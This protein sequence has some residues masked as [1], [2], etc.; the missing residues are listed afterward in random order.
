MKAPS[1]CVASAATAGQPT[2]AARPRPR[3]RMRDAQER[4]PAADAAI[5]PYFRD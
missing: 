5:G 2:P 4:R 3:E 1:L